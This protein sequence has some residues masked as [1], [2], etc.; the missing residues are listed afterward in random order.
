[1]SNINTAI[2]T[3]DEQLFTELTPEEGAVVEGGSSLRLIS[4]T[5]V[6]NPFEN[7]PAI[8]V[9]TRQVFSDQNVND[10]RLFSNTAYEFGFDTI[11]SIWDQDNGAASDDLLGYRD[12]TSAQAGTGVQT[13]NALNDQGQGYRLLYQVL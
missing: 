5:P 4:L 12:A 11:V 13:L 7:D 6:G 3:S 9:G 10:T 8:L 2:S 1:M